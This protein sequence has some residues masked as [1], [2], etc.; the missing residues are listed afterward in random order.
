MHRKSNK[1]ATGTL[2]AFILSM[3]A[4]AGAAFQR[5]MVDLGNEVNFMNPKDFKDRI[6]SD[7]ASHKALFDE[8]KIQ[9]Q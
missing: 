4:L 2:T 8:L 1:A 6:Y 5:R 7:Y 3:A 9:K